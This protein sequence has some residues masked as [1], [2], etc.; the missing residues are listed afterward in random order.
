MQLTHEDSSCPQHNCCLPAYLRSTSCFSAD[1]SF[2][3]LLVLLLPPLVL[4][5]PAAPCCSLPPAAAPPAAF[6]FFFFCEEW[7][8]EE[9]GCQLLGGAQ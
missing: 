7:V 9:H 2:S 8:G 1:V 3:V 6:F 4:M 5:A